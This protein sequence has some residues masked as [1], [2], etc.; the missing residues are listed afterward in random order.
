LIRISVVIP[1]R[2]RPGPLAACLGALSASFPPDAETVVVSD[3]GTE[4]PGPVVAPFVD[5]LRLRLL[6]VQHRG[7]AA[8]RNRG[9]EVAQGQIVAFT[10]DDCLPQP[11]WV[12]SLATGVRASP[13]RA[14][15]GSTRVGTKATVS[16][17]AAQLVLLL[18]SRHDRAVAG[19]E[20]LLPSNNFAC[21]ADAL[22]RLGGFDESFRTA[23]D[24]ELCR[25]WAQAGF[26]LGRVSEAIVEHDENLDLGGFVRKFFAYGRG[27][28]R[29]HGSGADP[30]LRES[31]RFHFRLPALVIPELRQRG[32]VRSAAIA[33][34]LLLWEISNVA[35]YLAEKARGGAEAPASADAKA[36]A[37]VR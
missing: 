5:S 3:G 4:D 1:T 14:V 36:A 17:E 7:P 37:K 6:R 20:R 9:L 15:G 16:A 19:R 29:F 32:L 33:A 30:S 25:R 18:L 10:D 28:A 13:P 23:E 34:L 26:E 35:G 2:D 24:R 8:A 21:P 11:G 31:I 22:V 12:A 27:A